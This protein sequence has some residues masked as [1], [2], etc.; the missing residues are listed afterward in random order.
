MREDLTRHGIVETRTAEEVDK[1]LRETPGTVMM[2]INSVCG[3]AAGKARPGVVEAL[4]NGVVP[5]RSATAFAGADLEA[6]ARIRELAPNIPAT[7][8]AVYLF[9]DGKPVYG[10]PRNGIE[11]RQ[12]FEIAKVLKEAFNE[13]CTPADSSR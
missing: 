2:V 13:H 11:S 1:L 12:S 8:P 3:C 7:S 5:D 10:L 4:Q 9:R 6:V